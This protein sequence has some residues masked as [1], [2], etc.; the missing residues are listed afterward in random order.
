M[1]RD[2]ATALYAA[3][4]YN[5]V[6]VV[7]ELLYGS[8]VGQPGRMG[9]RGRRRR[10]DR[11]VTDVDRAA[12]STGITPLFIAA[13]LGHAE[14]VGLLV[15]AGA[16]RARKALNGQTPLDTARGTRQDAVVALLLSAAE[17]RSST[18]G[19]GG[20]DAVKAEKKEMPKTKKT[21]NKKRKRRNRRRRRKKKEV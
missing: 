17:G 21:R 9:R 12:P 10:P 14:V 1:K 16:D 6:A 11:Y 4:M 18:G 19:V 20:G 13:H 7:R 3:A 2:G 5:H 15:G 8:S